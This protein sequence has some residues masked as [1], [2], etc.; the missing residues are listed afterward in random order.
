ME[1]EGAHAQCPI[2]GDA[3]LWA[4]S[5]ITEEFRK[6]NHPLLLTLRDR[7]TNQ[8]TMAIT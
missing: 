7:R 4:V 2:S 8:Q 1:V 3:R 6:K 5:C